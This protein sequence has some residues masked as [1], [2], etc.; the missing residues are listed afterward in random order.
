M[1]AKKKKKSSIAKTEIA[2]TVMN[3]SYGQ[4]KY[5]QLNITENS[6]SSDLK[7]QE[8]MNFIKGDAQL[9]LVLWR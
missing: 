6:V 2:E 7:L 3:F 1:S 8:H 9:G 4:E 5:N